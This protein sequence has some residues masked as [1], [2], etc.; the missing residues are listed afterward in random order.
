MGYEAVLEILASKK[1]GVGINSQRP[2][3]KRV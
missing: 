1:T 2:M 3:A